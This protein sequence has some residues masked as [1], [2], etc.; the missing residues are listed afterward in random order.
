MRRRPE[1]YENLD[2]E[3]QRVLKLVE[4]CPEALRPKAFEILLQGLV[5]G[6]KPQ[7]SVPSNAKQPKMGEGLSSKSDHDWT[8]G[9]PMDVLPRLKAMA[10][11]RGVQPEQLAGLFDFSSDPFTFAPVHIKGTG[12]Y[13]RT[14]KAALLVACRSFLA[15][16]KW[17]GD[18]AE[19]KAMC[20]HQNCY[21]PGN[22]SS[23][24]KKAKGDILK[25]VDVGTSVELSATGTEQAETLLAGLAAS[26]V[27][28]E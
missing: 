19:V 2:E 20:A 5:D 21:D 24:M 26:D 13:D 18:W 1:M 3:L 11:R 23:T 14:K 15:T 25:D 22:F 16:G 8:T 10:K 12:A 6:M 17:V 7:P 9:I 28:A 4:S 27:S